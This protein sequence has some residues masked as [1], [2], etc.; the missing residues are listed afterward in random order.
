MSNNTSAV[1]ADY[2]ATTTTLTFEI[3]S[4]GGTV[5]EFSIPINDENLCE[6]TE[7][8][9]LSASIVNNRGTFSTGG[10]MATGQITDN[11]GKCAKL[12]TRAQLSSG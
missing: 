4:G 3:F 2:T 9:G 7:S 1:G 10:N 8:F 5:R 11:D 6:S 12:Y